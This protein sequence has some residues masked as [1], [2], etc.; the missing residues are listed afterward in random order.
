MVRR[1]TVTYG[2]VRTSPRIPGNS[3]TPNLTTK[4][5]AGRISAIS[6]AHPSNTAS[7]R[8]TNARF[9]TRSYLVFLED[10]DSRHPEISY[11]A[12][13]EPA[14]MLNVK[15]PFRPGS[16]AAVSTSGNQ[17]KQQPLPRSC[18]ASVCLRMSCLDIQA[19]SL[20]RHNI[21]VWDHPTLR[22]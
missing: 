11:P 8:F 5:G 9:R 15:C 4:P 19:P 3:K 7:S 1:M 18:Q 21:W 20:F 6:H 12:S 10:V 16:A 2:Q 22:P 17:A 13:F 14:T